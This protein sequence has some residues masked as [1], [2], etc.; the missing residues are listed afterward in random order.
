M[1]KPE[2]SSVQKNKKALI[3]HESIEHYL[4]DKY[5]SPQRFQVYWEQ[6]KLIH[7]LKP[8]RVLEIGIGNSFVFE[9]LRQGGIQCTGIDIDIRTKP[10]VVGDVLH[11]PFKNESFDVV[12]CFEVLEHIPFEHFSAALRELRRVSQKTVLISI[13]HHIICHI[14]WFQFTR[15]FSLGVCLSVPKLRNVKYDEKSPHFWEIGKYSVPLKLVLKSMHSSGFK[16][17]RHYILKFWPYH[18]F[19]ILGKTPDI[20][21]H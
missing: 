2:N 19:F 18:R 7:S 20:Q 12:A 21:E 16:I 17:I 13:P 15:W 14:R 3:K 6:I 11:L 5:M 1:K 9:F 8:S 10:P 4:T